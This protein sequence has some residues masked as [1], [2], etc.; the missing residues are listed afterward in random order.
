MTAKSPAKLLDELANSTEFT[1]ESFEDSDNESQGNLSFNGR[2]V[3]SSTDGPYVHREL[4][5]GKVVGKAADV[6][7]SLHGVTRCSS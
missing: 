5:G 6:G 3:I 1:D 2:L 4:G 7:Y